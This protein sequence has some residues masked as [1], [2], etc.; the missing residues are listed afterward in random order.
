MWQ[1]N[2]PSYEAHRCKIKIPS[3]SWGAWVAQ[4]VKHPTL[5]FSLGHDLMVHEFEPC[6][7]LCADSSEPEACSLSLCP[8][9]TPTLSLSLKNK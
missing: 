4:L 9:P 2:L 6:V 7:G 5:G 8:S 3:L 1:N